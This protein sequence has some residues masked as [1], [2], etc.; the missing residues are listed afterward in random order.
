MTQR[1]STIT[2]ESIARLAD[3]LREALRS[4]DPNFRK[5][6]LRLF[7]GEVIVGDD[8]IRVRG[9]KLALAKATSAAQLPP[10]GGVVLSFVRE[11]RPGCDETEN[12]SLI[13]SVQ[14]SG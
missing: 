14:S 2:P 6:Y 5:A 8:E 4:D 10:A 9:P 7:A 13:V 12:W 1:A 11:W 3:S